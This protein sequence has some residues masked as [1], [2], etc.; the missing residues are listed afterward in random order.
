MGHLGGF[1]LQKKKLR[2]GIKRSTISSSRVF[3]KNLRKKNNQFLSI[4]GVS[5]MLNASESWRLIWEPKSNQNS[6]LDMNVEFPSIPYY[7]TYNTYKNEQ[8]DVSK[9]IFCVNRA[10]FRPYKMKYIILYSQFRS[11]RHTIR[12]QRFEEV[13][14]RYIKKTTTMN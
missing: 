8:I 2:N 4:D 12:I 1:Q 3:F 14:T 7:S 13:I 5:Y 6:N 10:S 11:P 9:K